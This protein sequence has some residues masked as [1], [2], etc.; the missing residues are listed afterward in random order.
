[1]ESNQI[2]LYN[3]NKGI[4]LVSRIQIQGYEKLNLHFNKKYEICAG[5]KNQFP[6]EVASFRRRPKPDAQLQKEK[7]DAK[8]K[9][10]LL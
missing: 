2:N 1:M 10:I 4:D 6:K 8:V 9:I 3:L 5:K 7:E